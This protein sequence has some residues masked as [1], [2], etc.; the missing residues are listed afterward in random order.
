MNSFIKY[1]KSWWLSLFRVCRREFYIVSHDV[2]VMLFFIALP[3]FYPIAYTLIYNPEL[4]EEVPFCVV[5]DSRT[6]A[7]R[8]LVQ[9]ADATQSMQLVGYAS[10]MAE[11]RRCLNAKACYGIMFIPEDYGEKLAQG[12]QAVVPFFYEMSLLMRY[13]TFVSALTDLQ[14]AVGDEYREKLMNEVG[15]I[16]SELNVAAIDSQAFM[17]GAESQ[18]FA[19]FVIPGILILILQQSMILGIAMLGG[20][21]RDRKRLNNGVDPLTVDAPIVAT[22]LGKTICYML[23]Y[24]PLTIYI[25]HYVPLLFGLPHSGSAVDYLL[26]IVPFLLSTAFMGFVMQWFVSERESSMLVVVFTSVIFLFLS[27]LTWPRYAMDF[28]WRQLS[29]LIPATWGIEGFVHINSNGA[30]LSHA[31]TPYTTLWLLTALYFLSAYLLWKWKKK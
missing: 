29:A 27:G 4:V 30:T 28:P 22:I 18:G 2:G 14:M 5:D 23:I 25:L 6:S 10:D 15:D 11:A 21:S 17:L 3:L 26:F 24:A 19:S 7:S 16:S 31:S 1:I 8:K 9:M 13:R 20:T 12:E